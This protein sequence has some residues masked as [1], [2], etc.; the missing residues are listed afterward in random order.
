MFVHGVSPLHMLLN[1][2]PDRVQV[3]FLHVGRKLVHDEFDNTRGICRFGWILEHQVGDA[4]EQLR[5]NVLVLDNIFEILHKTS[6][7]GHVRDSVALH[8]F[9]KIV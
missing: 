8:V 6:E 2:C 7:S 4:C 5:A 9:L 1:Q 3:S